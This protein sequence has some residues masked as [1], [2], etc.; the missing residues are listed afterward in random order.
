MSAMQQGPAATALTF[1]FNVAARVPYLCRLLRKVRGAG[2]SAWVRLNAEELDA[3]DEALWTF[4]QE[5]FIAHAR[6]GAPEAAYSQVLLSD[7]AE[8]RQPVQVMVNA[9]PAL[10]ADVH[11]FQRVVEIVGQDDQERTLARQRWRE[12]A[13]AGLQ[14][15]GHDAAAVG[16]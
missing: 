2:L 8:P 3:L 9:V 6:V 12:Y 7:G 11:R 4:S 10:V 1:H 15:V 14:P 13:Q 16:A 5:E